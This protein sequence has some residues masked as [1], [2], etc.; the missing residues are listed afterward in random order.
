MHPGMKKLFYNLSL[1]AKKVNEQQI[2]RDKLRGYLQKIRIV[3]AQSPKKSVISA[4][5]EKLEKHISIMLDKKLGVSRISKK[6]YESHAQLKKKE[7]E[8]DLKIQKL[9]ELLEK[10][11]KKVNEESL[12]EQL[13][14]EI[15][16]SL[17]EEME[18]KLYALEAKYY[19]LKDN[20]SY[21]ES[22]LERIKERISASKEKLRELKK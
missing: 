17:V 5:L 22:L 7:E 12:K 15:K 3:A 13:N 9:N 2:S 20:P 21:P 8:L 16:P 19:E 10:V 14:E 6:E 4:E 1:A 18:D 11:G